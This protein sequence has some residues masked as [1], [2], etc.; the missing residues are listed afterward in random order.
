[1]IEIDSLSKHF[2]LP[3][4]S[5]LKV[6]DTMNITIDTGDFVAIMGQSGQGK[7]TFLNILSGL[8]RNYTGS[9][10]VL[11]K[12]LEELSESEITS[13]RGRHISYV[14]QDY[15]LIDSLT[16]EENIEL[17]LD[18]NKLSRRYSIDDILSIVGLSSKK[19]SYPI[20]LSGGEKQRVALARSFIGRSDI[21]LADEPTGSLDEGNARR[22]MVLLKQLWKETGCTIIMITHSEDIAYFAESQYILRDRQLIKK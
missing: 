10:K 20:E 7:T 6:F 16:V 12:K 22:V 9:V 1:M 4:T 19:K 5:Y 3:D 15:N 11:G 8:E 21:I 13:F 17:I 2:L 14:F 18:I